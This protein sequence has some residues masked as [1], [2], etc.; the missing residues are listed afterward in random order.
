MNAPY[1]Y[2]RL[3]IFYE[4]NK[5]A[6]LRSMLSNKGYKTYFVEKKKLKGQNPKI[7]R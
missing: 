1:D 6:K 4:I 3:K 5:D 2:L 7:N